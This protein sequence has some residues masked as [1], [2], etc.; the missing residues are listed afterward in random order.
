MHLVLYRKRTELTTLVVQTLLP[1]RRSRL[2][3]PTRPPD[4]AKRA[5]LSD[6][7]KEAK[8]NGQHRA[9]Q[10]TM[11]SDA[12]TVSGGAGIRQRGPCKQPQ[13]GQSWPATTRSV[14]EVVTHL[15][16]GQREGLE[17]DIT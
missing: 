2:T 6:R 12:V 17:H 10:A 7:G 11:V 9:P 15:V 5:W 8:A 16:R 3:L 13:S 14:V 1:L 4:V